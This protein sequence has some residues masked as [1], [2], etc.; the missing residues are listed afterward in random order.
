MPDKKCVTSL[1]PDVLRSKI[2]EKKFGKQIRKEFSDDN[3]PSA[4][5]NMK[6]S[7]GSS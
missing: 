6:R 3:A 5:P 1:S 2:P 4:V 7:N